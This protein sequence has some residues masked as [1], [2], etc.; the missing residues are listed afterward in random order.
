[1]SHVQAMQHVQFKLWIPKPLYQIKARRA[2]Y[3]KKIEIKNKLPNFSQPLIVS[4][5]ST[6]WKWILVF[7]TLFVFLVSEPKVLNNPVC[8]LPYSLAVKSYRT[9][10]KYNWENVKWSN[11]NRPWRNHTKASA[12]EQLCMD[13][14]P[15]GF[16]ESHDSLVSDLTKESL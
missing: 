16:N 6:K 1:M 3:M 15:V 9:F 7:A 13:N 5:M 14:I 2:D 8:V 10:S 12:A 11:K 4:T